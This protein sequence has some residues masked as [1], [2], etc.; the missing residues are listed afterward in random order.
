MKMKNLSKFIIVML[1]SRISVSM[2]SWCI[3]HD[4]IV[5][6]AGNE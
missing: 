5:L 6:F 3:N 2:K 1:L 4:N